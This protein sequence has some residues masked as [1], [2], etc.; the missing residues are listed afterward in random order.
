MIYWFGYHEDT[1]TL[2]QNALGITV[3]DDFPAKEDIQL[4]DLS[5]AC[6]SYDISTD[7]IQ[8]T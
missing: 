7:S 3:L 6:E 8:N 4:L 2:T 1:A 5:E